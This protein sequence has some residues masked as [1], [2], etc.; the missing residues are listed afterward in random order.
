MSS[1]D[2]ID[3]FNAR[4]ALYL[5]QG[6][7]PGNYWC[8]CYTCEMKFEGDKRAIKCFACATDAINHSS[9]IAAMSSSQL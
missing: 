7:A 4:R 2:V 9:E 5:G 8:K 6:Y 3:S 1:P